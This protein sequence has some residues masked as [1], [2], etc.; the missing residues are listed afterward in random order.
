[1]V[2]TAAHLVDQVIPR[3]L[4]R[5][6]V[7]SFPIPLRIPFAPASFGAA[8]ESRTNSAFDSTRLDP[9]PPALELD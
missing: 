2:E 6:W 9:A 1:M 8:A 5:Q 7:L 3:V 4:V